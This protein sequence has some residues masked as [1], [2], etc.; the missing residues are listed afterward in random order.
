MNEPSP[1]RTL[2][3][4][5]LESTVFQVITSCSSEAVWLFWGAYRL[6]RQGRKI[7]HASNQQEASG[8]RSSVS[9]LLLLAGYLAYSSTLMMELVCSSESSVN[10]CR[11]IRR[12]VPQY[13]TP[14]G[15]TYFSLLFNLNIHRIEIYFKY[16]LCIWIWSMSW[17]CAT[18]LWDD[19]FTNAVIF[20]LS[21]M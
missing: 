2:T 11:P 1:L 9:F 5:H 18:T 3:C 19:F 20:Y 8:N 21:F 14:P 13:S 6:D 15:I 7:S 4:E 17:P 10:V 16:S 12:R